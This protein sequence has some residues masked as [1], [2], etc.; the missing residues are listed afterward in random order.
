MKLRTIYDPATGG[1][2]TILR[3]KAK[4][5]EIFD[6]GLEK[7]AAAMFEVMKAHNGL[8]LAAPQVS[9]DKRLIVFGQQEGCL[10]LPGL[11]LPVTRSA[12]V[13]V[14]AQRLDGRPVTIKA[15]GM[16]A[17]IL[18]HEIDHLDGILFTD[19]ADT[20]QDLADYRWAK[21]VFFGSDDFSLPV[22]RTLRDAGLN[23][24]AAVTETDKPSGRGRSLQ[25]T[26]IKRE[27]ELSGAAVFQ[28][29]NKDDITS[30]VEQLK[31]DLVVL[32]S[33]GKILPPKALEA[34]LFG[35]LNVHPSLLPKYRG[36]TPIQSALLGGETETGVTI[37][38]M[39]PSVDTG[40]IVAQAVEP[41]SAA[42][43]AETL[44]SRLSE[45]GAA[46]LVKSI[47]AYLSAQAKITPQ[48]QTQATATAK[49]T[50]EMGEIDWSKSLEVI[51][52][53]IRAFQPWPGAFTFVEGK[54]L[55]ILGSK[56][57]S[58][59][60]ILKIVQLEGKRPAAWEDF[61]RGYAEALKNCPW[62]GRIA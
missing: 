59:K 4:P 62:Y 9:L 11:E 10:S 49:L 16:L 30:I 18:Q 21:I 23:I 42:D 3:R 40:N 38:V 53:E 29:E 22:F 43:T 47:P 50:K 60:L 14:E 5:V 46:L 54:R 45:R 31:P 28:P 33:Y 20:Y 25:P 39:A 12:G 8:G 6:S 58:G 34:P 26:P 52:R 24:I 35:A 36:A 2:A 32:A 7:Y 55:K 61:R 57:E 19:R 1:Y 51:D 48:D 37:M 56:L 44:R 13:T 17:R 41:I 15:K 27:A